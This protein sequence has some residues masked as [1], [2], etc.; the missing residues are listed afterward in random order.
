MREGLSSLEVAALAG[1]DD[2]FGSPVNEVCVVAETAGVGCT[3]ASLGRS[4]ASKGAGWWVL[5]IG[6]C[7]E[8]ESEDCDG[9]HF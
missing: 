8:S 2:A 5:C 4:N 7:D 9:L 3:A 6:N 1:G